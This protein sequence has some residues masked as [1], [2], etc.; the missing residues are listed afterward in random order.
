MLEPAAD[1]AGDFDVVGLSGHARAQ[2]A[3]AADEEFHLDARLGA[4]DELVHQVGVVEGVHLNGDMARGAFGNL[5]VEEFENSRFKA[6]G[7]HPEGV[8]LRREF[9][10]AERGKCGFGLFADVGV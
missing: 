4:L 3:D 5:P 2:A 9:A 6:E 7:S 1:H 10:C 8:H